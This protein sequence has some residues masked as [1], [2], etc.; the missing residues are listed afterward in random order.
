MKRS[1]IG[2]VC[3]EL[4]RGD[5]VSGCS[6]SADRSRERLSSMGKATLALYSVGLVLVAGCEG[7]MWGNLAVLA[8]SLGIF[9]G[10][11]TLGRS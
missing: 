2:V 11:H 3:V 8:I 7:A 1:V 4:F 10:T 6:K 5:S 9:M